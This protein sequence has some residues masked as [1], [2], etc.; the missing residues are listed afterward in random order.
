[1]IATT[2]HHDPIPTRTKRS[3]WTR[4]RLKQDPAVV[5]ARWPR[6]PKPSRDVHRIFCVRTQIVLFTVMLSLS[7]GVHAADTPKVSTD[8][9]GCCA[10]ELAPGAPLSDGSLYQLDST[11]TND[12]GVEVK[13]ASLHGRPQVV[14]M[15]FATC[16]LTCP[17]LI[18]DLKRVEAALPDN[19]RTN[20]GFLL[21]TFDADRDTPEALAA[22]RKIHG[23]PSN[24]TLLRGGADD[25]LEFS[26]LLGVKYKKDLRGQF[27]H[28]NVITVLDAGGEMVRQ[29]AGLNREASETVKAVE[30]ALAAK[31]N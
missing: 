28:S 30:Q 21:V 8:K 26:A 7:I 15:F 10:K 4:L 22:Y 18:N 16:Q 2:T 24:W 1:M 31:R 5:G 19:V 29:I 12:A 25:I 11:W 23:L 6:S 17:I 9:P 13:L 20:I 27:A 14:S 3:V